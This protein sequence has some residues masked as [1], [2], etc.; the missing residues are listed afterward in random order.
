MSIMIIKLVNISNNVAKVRQE[1]KLVFSVIQAEA[2]E[3]AMPL[4]CW[5]T[6][7]LQMK[8]SYCFTCVFYPPA[9]RH[10]VLFDPTFFPLGFSKNHRLHSCWNDKIQVISKNSIDCRHCQSVISYMKRL[11]QFYFILFVHF[12]SY[13]TAIVRFQANFFCQIWPVSHFLWAWLQ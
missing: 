10:D 11:H 8:T 6:H 12:N 7:A 9:P 2:Q 13:E 4:F 1:W 3:S 5:E